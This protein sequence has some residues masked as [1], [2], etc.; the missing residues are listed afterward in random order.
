V[1]I[2]NLPN[3]GIK[4]TVQKPTDTSLKPKVFRPTY[5]MERVSEFLRTSGKTLNKQEII[6]GVGGKYKHVSDAI[7]RLV[8]EGYCTR[9]I[10][11]RK[12]Q[13]IT[14][15]KEYREASNSIGGE[16]F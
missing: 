4:I 1:F 3:G 15:V 5:L 13:Q 2:T 14:F 10:G 7:D 8:V 11:A 9:E 16:P 12:A 6:D